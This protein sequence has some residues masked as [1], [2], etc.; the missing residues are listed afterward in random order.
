MAGDWIKMRSELQSH[1]KVV[2][3]LSATQSDKF[4]VIGG[5][6]AMWAV[7]DTHSTDGTLFGYTPDLMDHVIGWPGF[8]EAMLAVNWLTYD[9]KQTLILPEFDEHNSQGAKRRAEDQKRKRNERRDADNK[10]TPTG[11]NSDNNR[12]REEKRREDKEQKKDAPTKAGAISL[13]SFLEEC[14]AIGELAIPEDDPVY[15]YAESIGLPDEYVALAWSWFKVS[16]AAKRQKGIRGWRQHFRDAVRG[17]WPKYWYPVDG[18]GWALT[19]AGIQAERAQ[20]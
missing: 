3:I 2:R 17:N 8:S 16:R 19:T 11:Q 12:T 6:H 5:L 18:G 15:G 20:A 1:P 14:T 7:F 10:E 4:R 13:Q 9:G